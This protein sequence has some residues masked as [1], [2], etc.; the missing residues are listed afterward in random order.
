VGADEHIG[1]PRR[2]ASASE[3]EN[4]GALMRL[5]APT[6]GSSKQSLS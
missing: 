2:G 4:F 3:K 5:S 6:T 1:G